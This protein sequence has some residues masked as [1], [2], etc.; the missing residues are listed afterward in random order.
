MDCSTINIYTT[1]RAVDATTKILGLFGSP[2]RYN[3]NLIS[4]WKIVLLKCN[5]PHPHHLKGINEMV[6]VI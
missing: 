3:N 5:F 4:K 6:F 2:P 1:A